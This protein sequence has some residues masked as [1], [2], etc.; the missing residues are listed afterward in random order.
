MNLHL[1]LAG[2][3]DLELVLRYVRA[4]HEFEGIKCPAECLPN[5]V[6]SLMSTPEWG[7]LWLIC[8][9]TTPI[10]YIAAC[11]G[12]SIEFCGR[13]AF[14]DELFLDAE[15][16]GG[17]I[18]KAVLASVKAELASLGIKALHLQVAESNARALRLYRSAG[19]MPRQGFMFLSV[20]L[21]C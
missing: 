15:Y 21:E 2:E 4:Y 14:I 9:G 13:D 20:S 12:Y 8:I 16:R 3:A 7:R 5:S 6:L 11:F 10:G 18:G 1:R 19:L 17:G